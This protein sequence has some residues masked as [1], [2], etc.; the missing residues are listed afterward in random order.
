MPSAA[1]TSAPTVDVVVPVK[2][3]PRLEACVRAL[4]AQ[5]HPAGKL[6]IL[7]ADNGSRHPRTDLAGLDPRIEFLSEPRPGSYAARNA[8][9]ARASG[10][11]LAFT[12]SDTLP[13]PSWVSAA[14][15]ALD[16]GARVVAG[17]V[18]VY[19]R[20]ARRP[21]PVEAFEVVNAFRQ[22]R[23]VPRGFAVTANLVVPREV[24]DA[25]G[26][27]DD[28]LLSGGDAQWCARAVAAGYPLTYVPDAVV[29]HPARESYA[30]AWKKLC[31][32]QEGRQRRVR[33]GE[34][35]PG[36]LTA[37]AFAPPVGALARAVRAPELSG[38]RS[39]AAYVVG[40]FY[41]RYGRAAAA[42]KH[43]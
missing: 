7:V 36:A 41:M 2:D 10:D 21:H 32:V 31:R 27:F 24:F 1:P 29:R 23:T 42:L 38:A 37:K 28:G 25:V 19:P 13:D 22:D 34:Q 12:D 16:A 30:E 39:R 6:R 20:D 4:L 35:P 17:R 26:P 9:V 5:D 15:R 8:A 11:V 33:D 3:D 40:A 43:R 14:V 18:R